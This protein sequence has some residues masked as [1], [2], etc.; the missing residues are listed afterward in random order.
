MS[1]PSHIFQV[2][3]VV[4]AVDEP[5]H[6]AQAEIERRRALKLSV[7]IP[8]YNERRT[9]R[10]IFRRVLQATLPVAIEVI[11]VDDGS[12]D[13]SFE[14]LEELALSDPRIKVFR[15]TQNQG[16]G[17][18]I[19]TAIKEMT[20]D[21]AIVQDA[22]LEYDPAE[23]AKVIE[24][25]LDGRA[26]AVFGTRFGGSE[27]HRVLYY[28][29]SVGNRLL[30]WLTNIVCDVNLSDMETCYKAVKADIL[31]Q[32][33]LRCK[34]FG[35]EP[36]LTVR[37]A[38]WGAR[39]YEVPISYS[40][41]TY[42]EGKKITWKDAV[43]ALRVL[44]W[45]GFLDKQ[46]T[47]HDGYYVLSA[48]RGSG[49]NRWMF[50]QFSKFVGNKVLEAGCG[51]GNLTSLM[52]NR[53]G[54]LCVDVDPLYI[55]MISRRFGHLE[56]F[57]ASLMDLC[58]NDRYDEFEKSNFDTIICLNVLEH[59]PDDEQVLRNFYRSLSA[60]GHAI[61]LVPQH[62]WLFSAVDTTV[63][64]YRRYT[65][66]ELAKKMKA[67]GFTIVSM[68]DFNKLGVPGWLYN[69]VLGRKYLSPN[70]MWCF[71]LVLPI[72]KLVE[73]VGV[74]PALSAIAIVRKP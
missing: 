9:V 59:L 35:I 32:T 63:G 47:T 2:N 55:E 7:L 4:S 43:D 14:I 37:L 34:R 20:G 67:A 40:G 74:L 61:V 53:D 65:K 51:I 58:D 50:E 69:K 71:N 12:S 68:Q 52:L 25:I 44:I 42:A 64:H 23:I 21:I 70:Q 19:H 45:A 1:E 39:I 24:P 29:H 46:F 73:R 28:W 18:A 3:A 60:G 27:C 13:G 36:E 33:P 48:I 15:H 17:A 38:Q 31:K 22:D 10:T 41:R 57:E 66:D 54:L 6:Q 72:A 26:E 62:P 11:A 56:N 49:L 5:D 8:V 30:T 16:K